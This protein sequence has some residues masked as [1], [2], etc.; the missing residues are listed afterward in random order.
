MLGYFCTYYW[1]EEVRQSKHKHAH[2]FTEW[3]KLTEALRVFLISTEEMNT[4]A[5]KKHSTSLTLLSLS[6]T[7]ET[8]EGDKEKQVSHT[9]VTVVISAA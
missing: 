2:K 9:F 4:C 5:K 7:K 8:T 6:V 3:A 1:R